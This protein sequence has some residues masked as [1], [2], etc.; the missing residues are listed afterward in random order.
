MYKRGYEVYKPSTQ[1]W[2]D[3]LEEY[4]DFDEE[5]KR[6]FN[7][8]DITGSYKFTPEVLEDTDMD[9][10]IALPR[11]R[12]GPKF[13]KVKKRLQDTNII[14]IFRNHDNNMLDTRFYEVEY[15][16]GY[17]ASLAANVISK[18]L[19]EQVDE[20]GNRFV[21]FDWIVDHSV[22]NIKTMHQGAE[23]FQR[24]EGR[25]KGRLPKDGNI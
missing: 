11:Y 17:K 9:M 10:E 23:S 2:A 13:Y 16:D 14:P 7:N 24:V 8:A 19:F 12:E 20:E 1:D 22:D 21:L 3:M 6:V 18:N 5:F 4:P 25:D 15:L